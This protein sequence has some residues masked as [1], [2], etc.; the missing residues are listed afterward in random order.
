LT[1]GIETLAYHLEIFNINEPDVVFKFRLPVTASK[2][3][4]PVSVF[5][6]VMNLTDFANDKQA[7]NDNVE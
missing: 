2:S 3:H 1:V 7:I 4:D 6:E 5:I